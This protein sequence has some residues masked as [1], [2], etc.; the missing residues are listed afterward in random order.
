MAQTDRRRDLRAKLEKDSGELPKSW[1]P[2]VGDLLCGELVRYD[3]GHTPYGR[4]VIAVVRDEDTEELRGV[5]LIHHVLREK[6]KED[7]PRP[8]EWVA[9][10]RL[11]DSERGY[12]RYSLLL[13]RGP[14]AE[15]PDFDVDGPAAD[16][17]EPT[18][19]AEAA[20]ESDDEEI[21]F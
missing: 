3:S 15:V 17:P 16:A 4:A 8:G 12:R 19:A 7:R 18:A 9:I 20:P 13:D 10:K 2:K 6:F 5:W 11:P 1:I 14:T 21:P